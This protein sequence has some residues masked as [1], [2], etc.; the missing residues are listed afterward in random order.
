M[1]H[2]HLPTSHHDEWTSLSRW[3]CA[4]GSGMVTSDELKLSSLHE[5][6]LYPLLLQCRV[7][8]TSNLPFY[9]YM[10]EIK[11]MPSYPL[12]FGDWSSSTGESMSTEQ[13]SLVDDV[14][15]ILRKSPTQSHVRA[16]DF[17]LVGKWTHSIT[18]ADIFQRPLKSALTTS[19][20]SS[21]ERFYQRIKLTKNKG[22]RNC[23]AKHVFY[24]G[25]RI[26]PKYQCLEF[27]PRW[28][29]STTTSS[30]WIS[31]LASCY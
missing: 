11:F 21:S 2:D 6:D 1:T 24:N 18:T 31:C 26:T 27:Y 4:S 17:N 23:A 29:I 14:S 10:G 30:S 28:K 15:R 5:T 20:K 9:N 13:Q 3:L 12:S 8:M 22:C 16:R 25:W 19:P 7:I